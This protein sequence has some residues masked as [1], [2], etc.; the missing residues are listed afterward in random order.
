M[1]FA[2]F[3]NEMYGIL[4]HFCFSCFESCQK[5]PQLTQIL[6][7]FRLVVNRNGFGTKKLLLFVMF[8]ITKLLGKTF[9]FIRKLQ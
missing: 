1:W 8:K 2:R 4:S 9:R 6:K 5:I 3:I 7:T